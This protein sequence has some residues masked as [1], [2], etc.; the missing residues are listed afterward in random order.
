[1][2]LDGRGE[3]GQKFRVQGIPQ[4]VIVGRDGKIEHV[5]LGASP[6][7]ESSLKEVLEPLLL[8]TPQAVG[9]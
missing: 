7:L 5:H 8:E 3:V 2:A 6:D 1:V 4:T 9:E